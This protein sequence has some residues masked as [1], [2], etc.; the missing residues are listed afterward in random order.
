[1]SGVLNTILQIIV[2]LL[3]LGVLIM[4]HELGHFSVA[5]FFKIKVLEFWI[6]MGPKIL[7]WK[8]KETEY[9]LRIIPIGGMVRMEGEETS[10][11]DEGSFNQKHPAKRAAVIAAGPVTNILFALIIVIIVTAFSGFFVNAVKLQGTESPAYTA[12]IRDGDKLISVKGVGVYEPAIDYGLFTYVKSYE[13]VP[14]VVQRPGFEKPLQFSVI[15]N[16]RYLLGIQFAKN[17]TGK[18]A[19]EAVSPDTPASKAGVKKG[20]TIKEINGISM[21][22]NQQASEAVQANQDKPMKLVVVR[23]GK[24]VSFTISPTKSPDMNLGIGFQ[25]AQGNPIEVVG[26]SVNYCISVMRSNFYTIGW[27]FTGQV[28]FTELSGPVGMVRTMGDVMTYSPD[29]WDN[30]YALLLTAAFISLCLGVFN[31]LPFPALDGSKI[32]LLVIEIFTKKKLK[33]EKEAIISFIGLGLLLTLM[34]VVTV[35]DILK[36]F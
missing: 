9:S 31:L 11:E 30:L 19:I 12:G 7:K 22:T 1:M 5:K 3:V 21:S 26:A 33:P 32:L 24:E 14:I 20:D 18:S 6:F 8:R 28:S 13:P 2:P 10:S 35:M 27:L 17:T 36:F 15:P 29:F 25:K 4:V 16:A 23:D 34:A